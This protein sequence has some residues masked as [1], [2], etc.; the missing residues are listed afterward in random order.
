MLRSNEDCRAG[1]D[2][3]FCGKGR[4]QQGIT[5]RRTVNR[6]TMEPPE[7]FVHTID[8]NFAGLSLAALH[9]HESLGEDHRGNPAASETGIASNVVR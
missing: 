1:L 7:A 3:E 6:D 9:A 8:R 5:V 2:L 4:A